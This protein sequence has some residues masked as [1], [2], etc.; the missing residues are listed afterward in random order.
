MNLF[1]ESAFRQI[2]VFAQ[3]ICDILDKL[4]DTDLAR[5]PTEN[6]HSI[7]ELLKHIAMICEADLHISDEKTIEEMESYYSSKVISSKEEINQRII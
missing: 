3:S 1:C 7:G 2:N 5:R 4:E 6:K